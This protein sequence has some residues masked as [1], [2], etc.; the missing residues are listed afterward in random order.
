VTDDATAAPVWPLRILIA[1]DHPVYRDGLRS[2]IGR[3]PDLELVGEAE[4]G[5]EAVER[6]ARTHPAIVL[7][8][9]RMREMSGIEATRRIVASDPSAR[10]LI[11]TM[12]EDDESLF[13]AMR[14]GARGYIPKD[15][16]SDEIVAAIRSAALGEVIFGASMADRL[17]TFFTTGRS[18]AV[19]PFPELTERE[20]EILELIAAGRSNA[21]IAARL[22]I[23]G[24]TVRNHVANVFSKLQVPSRSEAI[25]RAREAGLGG[26]AADHVDTEHRRP[27]PPDR[28]PG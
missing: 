10:I 24:K 11:I 20:H 15:A 3:S 17:M 16:D 6:A 26:G 18:T 12:S 2:L 25:V 22:A 13:A 27:K 19:D 28:L 14:A 9:L 23:T 8:D 21:E 7:M 4:T 5:A 1:D